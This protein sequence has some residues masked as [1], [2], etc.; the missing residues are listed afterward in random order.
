MQKSP[1]TPRTSTRGGPTVS[2]STPGQ[3]QPSPCEP[4][5]PASQAT[6][7]PLAPPIPYPGPPSRSGSTARRRPRTTSPPLSGQRPQRA[8]GSETPRPCGR[9]GAVRGELPRQLHR[10]HGQECRA[11]GKEVREEVPRLGARP[12]PVQFAWLVPGLEC[13]RAH[14]RGGAPCSS[15]S[16]CGSCAPTP[17]S[18]NRIPCTSPPPLPR[19]AA[20]VCG[21]GRSSWI[22]SVKRRWF[23]SRPPW[24][25]CCAPRR[26][27]RAPERLAR[28]NRAGA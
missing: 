3:M 24:T 7:A 25:F 8:R 20:P 4:R 21:R 23:L 14:L 1:Q 22:G 15:W 2:R 16:G 13:C 5:W 28:C 26:K 18:R 6:T 9:G 27:A 12:P 10:E 11:R 19:C 17:Q